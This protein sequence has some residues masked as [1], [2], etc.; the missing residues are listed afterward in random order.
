MSLAR[1]LIQFP[2]VVLMDEPLS[3]LDKELKRK[4]MDSILFLQEKYKFTLI[5]V[6][7]DDWE[8][9]QLGQQFIQL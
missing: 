1:A 2:D 9:K 4:M 8:A 3:H 6:T 7:H 5:Y